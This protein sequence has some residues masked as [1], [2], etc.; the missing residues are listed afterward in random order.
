MASCRM[1]HAGLL[2]ISISTSSEFS[3]LWRDVRGIAFHPPTDALA[4]E[5]VAKN[6][7]GIDPAGPRW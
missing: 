6:V 2:P 7:L 3:R 1:I 4:H 5:L